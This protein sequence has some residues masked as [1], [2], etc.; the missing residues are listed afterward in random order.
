[1]TASD[2]SVRVPVDAPIL[3]VDD[4]TS[5]REALQEALQL[6]GRAT[7]AVADG[8]EAV[9]WL[10]AARPSLVLLDLSLPVMVG[11]EIAAALRSRYGNAVP[12]IVMSA[13]ADALTRARRLGAWEV[14]RKPF[15]LA[16]LL[17]VV[18]H[19]LRDTDR[20]EGR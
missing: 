11:E 20:R 4:D 9:A 17:D 10:Q 13:G 8:G 16:E 3:V 18:Q 6:G 19:A 12:I 14:L 2:V 7:A 5:L 1:M 15:D